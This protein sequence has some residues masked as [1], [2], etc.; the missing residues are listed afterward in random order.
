MQDSYMMFVYF[1]GL[2]AFA[3]LAGSGCAGNS[4][5]V[6]TRAPMLGAAEGFSGCQYLG[7][8]SVRLSPVRLDE[9]AA[10]RQLREDV[11]DLGGTHIYTD[12]VHFD[13]TGERLGGDVYTCQTS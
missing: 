10:R 6:R 4:A 1:I 8:T 2:L 3:V 11:M 9:N 5:T 13:P 12:D 7:Y